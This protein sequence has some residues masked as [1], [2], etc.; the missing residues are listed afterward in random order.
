MTV[1]T[2][3]A[4]GAKLRGISGAADQVLS[5]LSNGLILYSVAVVSTAQYFGRIS[6]LLTLLAAV[7]GTLRGALGNPLLLM[8]AKGTDAIRREGSFAV[9]AA[10]LVSPPL[11]VAM[12][13]L[14][15]NDVG[16]T[17]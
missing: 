2:Q 13:L 17:P 6:L 5:S 10:L 8:A 11:I 3:S 4:S 1:A 9:S 16:T 12:W 14:G 15:Q 7:V